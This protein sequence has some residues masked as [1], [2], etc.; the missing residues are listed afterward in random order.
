MISS[1]NL[2]FLRKGKKKKKKFQ[3][4]KLAWKVPRCLFLQEENTEFSKAVS[5]YWIR[6]N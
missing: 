4:L 2:Y 6:N 1:I 5:N 3:N